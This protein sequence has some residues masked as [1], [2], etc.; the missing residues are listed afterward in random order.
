MSE[1]RT[2]PRC[3]REL[4]EDAPRGLCPACLLGAALADPGQT[5]DGTLGAGDEVPITAIEAADVLEDR[6]VSTTGLE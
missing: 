2:C 4:P 1:N 6:G 5:A 3:N